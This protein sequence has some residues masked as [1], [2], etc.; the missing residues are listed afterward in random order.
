MSS[1]RSERDPAVAGRSALVT[2]AASGIGLAIARRLAAE[3]ARVTLVDL[4]G[5][6]LEAAVEEIDG[7]RAVAVDLRRRDEIERLLGSLER[8]DVLV[9]NAGLQHVSPLD[10]FPLDAWDRLLA[11]MLTAP[12]LLARGLLPGMYDAGW[13][14]I[15]N[16]ASVHGLVASP[17]KSAYVAAKH[18]LV[19]L[20]K[21]IALEAAARCP[22]VTAH[23][24]CPSYVRT[25]LVEG[26]IAA[27]AETHGVDPSTVV[28]EILLEAN[29]VK[30]LI[31]PEE[32]ADA[33]LYLCRPGAWSMTGSV[34]TMDAGWL[35]H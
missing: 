12:F 2:G 11:V 14:R 18:G 32:V 21:V 25:P 4:P 10:E 9:S 34:L 22:D 24:V 1:G 6:G 5:P 33:V 13:G 19:G 23:A 31:E 27:Q 20:T 26:Q 30:R 35:A 8:V 16:V 15:V 7:A 17:Y 3:R 29:A 28:G